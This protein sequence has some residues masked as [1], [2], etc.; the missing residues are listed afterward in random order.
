MG[1]SLFDIDGEIRAFLDNLY[2]SMDE[3]GTLPEADFEALEALNAERDRKI[4]NIAL[5][6]KELQ[7]E[8]TALK[9][10]A[11]KLTQR[12]KIATNKAERLKKYL[13]DSMDGQPYESAKNKISWR[14]SESVEIDEKALPKKYFTKKV[15]LKPDKTGIKELLRGGMKIKGAQLVKKNNIQIK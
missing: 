3:D 7:I 2:L 5:Y 8:A 12:A 9:A 4:D 6:Y 11:D 13:A 15:E 10:E 1:R 14:T